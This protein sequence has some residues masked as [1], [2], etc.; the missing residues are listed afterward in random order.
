MAQ[1]L[2]ATN[3]AAVTCGALQTLLPAGCLYGKSGASR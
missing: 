2:H 1:R 3:L